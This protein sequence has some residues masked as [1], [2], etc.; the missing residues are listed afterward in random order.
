MRLNTLPA[1]ALMLSANFA[2]HADDCPGFLAA[3]TPLDVGGIP[4][5]T[6]FADLD[7]DG[8]LDAVTT[9]LGDNTVSVLLNCGSGI[10][11]PAAHY[12][13]G[14]QSQGL[15]IGDLNGD[16]FADVIVASSDTFQDV[17]VLLGN[18]DGTLAP[19]AT[20]GV[21]DDLSAVAAGDVDGD[22]DTDVVAA[23]RGGSL[24][25]YRNNGSSALRPT[26]TSA[27]ARSRTS[28]S[29]TSTTT[30]G[31]TSRASTPPTAPSSCAFR[32]V[33]AAS[34]NR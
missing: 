19:A 12:P 18:G 25:I 29:P 10:F 8:D 32:T 1:I 4:G 6:E 3:Q 5:F 22:G 17:V 16:G 30:R 21:L 24:D 34:C 2:T 31:S 13:T 7:N 11:E 27:V 14:P 28:S 9:N 15:A 26:S 23:N 20:N 33:S